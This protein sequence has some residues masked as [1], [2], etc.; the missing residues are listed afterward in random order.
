MGIV[1]TNAVIAL[2]S[3]AIDDS[4]GPD[5]TSFDAAHH[6]MQWLEDA[7]L[8]IVVKKRLEDERET[9]LEAITN[10]GAIVARLRKRAIT[11]VCQPDA[12]TIADAARYRWLRDHSCP[13]HN[14]YISVPDEFSGVH[15]SPAQVDEYIDAAVAKQEAHNG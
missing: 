9:H 14:F 7:G 5:W 2:I 6:V 3:E 15:Y 12:Q 10:L 4:M 1:D 13:P 11:H 8:E